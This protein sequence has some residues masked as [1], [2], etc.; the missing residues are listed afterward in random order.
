MLVRPS[1][2]KL[3]LEHLFHDLPKYKQW[4]SPDSWEV[5]EHFMQNSAQLSEVNSDSLWILPILKLWASTTTH[6]D[7][8]SQPLSEEATRLLDKE[9]RVPNKVV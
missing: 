1:T 5:W 2:E 8:Q 9:T 4:L 6:V 3:D 7:T